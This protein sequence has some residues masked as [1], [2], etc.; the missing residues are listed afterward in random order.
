MRLRVTRLYLVRNMGHAPMTD[1]S[2]PFAV[3]R[4]LRAVVGTNTDGPTDAELL[5][6]FAANRDQGAFELLVWR[7][8]GMVTAVCRG[9]LRDHHAA[10]DA[11]QAA[12][13]ALARK[14]GTVRENPAGWLFRVASRIALRSRKSVTPLP[15][16]VAEIQQADREDDSI[17]HEELAR[18][19]EKYR[20]PILLCF[21]EGLSHADAA[22]R[23][24]WPTGT[25]AGRIARAKDVLQ[26]RLVR[27]GVTIPTACLTALFTT[28][29]I[30]GAFAA[31][32]TQA[33]LAFVSGSTV[34]G[35]SASVLPMA[36][37][38]IRAMTI[39]KLQTAAGTLLACA[40][41]TVGGVWAMGQGP[42]E[43][44]Q[45]GGSGLAQPASAGSP[46][47]S[48]DW[49]LMATGEK[50]GKA[51]HVSDAKVIPVPAVKS[52]KG[53]SP[54]GKKRWLIE[55][56]NGVPVSHLMVEDLTKE[57]N[58]FD[59]FIKLNGYDISER[60]TNPS[61]PVWSPDGKRIAYV[62][63]NPTQRMPLV[64]VVNANGTNP[65]RLTEQAGSATK[66]LFF[67]DSKSIAFFVQTEKKGKQVFYDLMIHNGESAKRLV[68][69]I[70]AYDASLSHDGKHIA[71]GWSDLT[72]YDAKSGKLVSRTPM[73]DVNKDWPVVF[74][75][76]VWR[77]DG[78]A[79]AFKP[80]FVGGIAFGPGQNREEMRLPGDAHIGVIDFSSEKPTAKTFEVGRGYLPDYWRDGV[81]VQERGLGGAA[82]G[83]P[84]EALQ[85]TVV[86]R[87]KVDAKAPTPGTFAKRE[88]NYLQRL[89]TREKLKQLMIAIH[90]YEATYGHLPHD[91]VD[92]KGKPLLSWRVQLLPYLEQA[93][94]YR[95][96]K[97]NEPWDSEHNKK[98]L[99]GLRVYSSGI[100]PKDLT[101]TH[102]QTFTGPG[103]AFNE[104]GKKVKF[105]DITDGTVSTIGVAEVGP[106]VPWTKPADVAYHPGK[107]FA[108]VEWPFANAIQFATASGDTWTVKPDI[109]EL[110]LRRMIERNDSE[111]VPD[112][113][114]IRPL[115]PAEAAEEKAMLA[116]TL[117]ANAAL[118]AEIDDVMKELAALHK[119]KNSYTT[120]VDKA[121]ELTLEF[122]RL[123]EGVKPRIKKERDDLGLRPGV[124]VPEPRELPKP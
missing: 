53:V 9:I 37:G 113:K 1:P 65:V 25:V 52:M 28:E 16:T 115:F 92:E 63:I 4:Y 75:N 74:T 57:P 60:G 71:I 58:A 62:A 23:L 27:R 39:S 18:L 30:G 7:H 78:K 76:L 12:F 93:N 97:L 117:D 109:G 67:P 80:Q 85:G 46:A 99:V 40:M 47:S 89:D 21:F 33:A 120:D 45:A 3:A 59:R 79:I 2:H 54:D 87:I 38:A 68:E 24:G 49:W 56:K 5:A 26:S 124:K 83:G 98:L 96:F 8:A 36:K 11:T 15:R 90:N 104:P 50:E 84:G 116:R 42:G 70:E 81:E 43:S 73:S 41:L 19:P 101:E 123:L 114:T 107:A 13:L 51:V 82:A 108:N 66:P 31:A 86:E 44:G 6:R 17:L 10:E 55:S 14:A 118:L 103:V 32:T 95:L 112:V 61:E 105:A 94:L 29:G 48:P 91:I 69:R 72:V 119:L 122:K 106:A 22:K 35:V 121:R 64:Y 88:S 100:D 102:F 77:P 111:V 20:V 110:I 34:T